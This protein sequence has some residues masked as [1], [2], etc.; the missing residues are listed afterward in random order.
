MVFSAQFA[1]QKLIKCNEKKEGIEKDRETV[2]E[3]KIWT[4]DSEREREGDLPDKGKNKLCTR[5]LTHS[6][7]SQIQYNLL[8]T[9]C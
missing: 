3:K 1:L 5:E 6:I 2:K 8:H 7:P 4:E 9:I